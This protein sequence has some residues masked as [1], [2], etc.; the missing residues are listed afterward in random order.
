MKAIVREG[1][2][3]FVRNRKY[4]AGIQI[5]APDLKDVLENQSWKVEVSNGEQKEEER[6]QEETE[7]RSDS[8]EEKEM[9]KDIAVDRMVKTEH[10][11]KR[12]RV[13]KCL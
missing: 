5:P 11:K 12:G 2:V 13:S 4:G 7:T 3:V 9:I 1:Y 10:T 6:K 8:S